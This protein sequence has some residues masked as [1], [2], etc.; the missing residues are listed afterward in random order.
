MTDDLVLTGKD[1]EKI[2]KK[3]GVDV[4][5]IVVNLDGRYTAGQQAE[6]IAERC[7]LVA[8]AQLAKA[9]PIIREQEREKLGAT[10]IS[11]AKA[12]FEALPDGEQGFWKG[13]WQCL[14]DKG[15]S[16][17]GDHEEDTAQES[18]QEAASGTSQAADAEG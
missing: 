12:G 11:R 10:F 7:D 16:L 1:W 8:K 15:E 13:Y 18:Q 4:L 14:L 6:L 3:A 9:E 17:K 2:N 5:D